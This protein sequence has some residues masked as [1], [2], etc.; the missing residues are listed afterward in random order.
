MESNLHLQNDLG[1]FGKLRI[2]LWNQ[3]W[4]TFGSLTKNSLILWWGIP[5]HCSRHTSV[6]EVVT[7]PLLR[8]TVFLS[9]PRTPILNPPCPPTDHDTRCLNLQ[10]PIFISLARFSHAEESSALS[11]QWSPNRRIIDYCSPSLG[12]KAKVP[13]LFLFYLVEILP[14]SYLY[15]FR[16]PIFPS[17]ILRIAS[18]CCIISEFPIQKPKVSAEPWSRYRAQP[19]RSRVLL[20]S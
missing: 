16:L 15:D 7:P 9:I 5:C 17:M 12:W 2:K 6:V 14:C 8:Y 13:S 1:M 3:V 4:C 11:F 20:G 18:F 10:A 19:C